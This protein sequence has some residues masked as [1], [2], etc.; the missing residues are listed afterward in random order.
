MFVYICKR[1]ILL[2]VEALNFP[3]ALA[4]PVPFQ[5][6]SNFGLLLHSEHIPV[7]MVQ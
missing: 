4:G 1:T 6:P 5:C 2:P 3:E 7:S